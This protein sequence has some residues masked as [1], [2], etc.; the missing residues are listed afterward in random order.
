MEHAWVVNRPLLT[1]TM[2]ARFKQIARL[3]TA[4]IFVAV[5]SMYFKIRI[6]TRCSAF[7]QHTYTMVPEMTWLTCNTYPLQQKAS[8]ART[9]YM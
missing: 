9:K 7:N 3:V 5:C 4:S 6:K 1:D 8:F 2:R